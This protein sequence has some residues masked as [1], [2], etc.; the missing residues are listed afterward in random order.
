MIYVARD[1]GF[2]TG[3]LGVLFALGGIGSLMGS[4]LTSRTANRIDARTWLVGSLA[5]W[6]VGSVATPLATTAALA[7]M[8]LIATQQIVGDAGAMAY[9]VADRTLRQTHAAPAL[10]AR[11]DA[12]VRTL[13]YSATLVGALVSGVLAEQFGARPLLF[14]SSVLLALAALAAALLLRRPPA[15]S[16]AR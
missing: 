14:A 11:V 10:L 8:V 6:A 15:S 3:V 4:W 12:S 2:E 7:G 9:H 13:G 1:I 5:L 16:P